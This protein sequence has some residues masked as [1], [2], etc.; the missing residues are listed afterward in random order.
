MNG[1]RFLVLK[2]RWTCRRARDCGIGWIAL[3]G[4]GNVLFPLPRGVA[5]GC[6]GL[7]LRGGRTIERRILFHAPKICTPRM[8]PHLHLPKGQRPGQSQPG[9]PP[10]EHTRTPPQALKGRPNAAI[11]TESPPATRLSL[12]F[13]RANGPP[14]RARRF[15]KNTSSP[16]GQRPGPSQP[17]APPREHARTPPH[18]LKGRPNAAIRTESPPATTLSLPFPRP[19][20]RPNAPG[21][22]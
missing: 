5:P 2:T 13:P 8:L 22:S 16:K 14:T 9:A 18:A 6:L 7:P 11:R 19:T 20:A 1:S 15:V 12:P 4:L 17:G 3:S 21:A 10:R